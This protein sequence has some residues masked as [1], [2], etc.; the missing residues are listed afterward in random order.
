MYSLNLK[1]FDLEMD[2]CKDNIHVG[3]KCSLKIKYGRLDISKIFL[4]DKN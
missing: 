3:I 1:I 2:G 4:H